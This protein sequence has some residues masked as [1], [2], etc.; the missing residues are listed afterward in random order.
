M[1]KLKRTGNCKRE[2]GEIDILAGTQSV[3]TGVCRT[4][5]FMDMN[6]FLTDDEIRDLIEEPKRMEL[7]ADALLH[8]MYDKPGR[9]SAFLQNAHK[10]PRI[11][12]AGEW[13]IYLRQSKAN[14]LDFSCG[15]GIIPQGGVEIFMLR[16]YNGKSHWHANPLENEAAFYAFHI[17]H[18]TERYQKSDYD[19]VHYACPTDR[20]VDLRGALPCMLHDFRVELTRDDSQQTGHQ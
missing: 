16:R 19:A 17:H 4:T 2:Y 9:E 13:Q 14:P 12:G 18:A 10:F 20:Y 7:T 15:L 1:L 6:F 8:N 3:I 5:N 11:G